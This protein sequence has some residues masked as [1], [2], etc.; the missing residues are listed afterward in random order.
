M[1]KTI[2]LE[3]IP[4]TAVTSPREHDEFFYVRLFNPAGGVN[5]YAVNPVSVLIVEPGKP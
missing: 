3:S 5:I 2:T 4:A 1:S